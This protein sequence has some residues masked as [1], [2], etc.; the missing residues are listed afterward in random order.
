MFFFKFPVY[1]AGGSKNCTGCFGLRRMGSVSSKSLPPMLCGDKLVWGQVL[2]KACCVLERAISVN[3][4]SISLCSGILREVLTKTHMDFS[5]KSS[6]LQ[7]F[8]PISC[9]AMG[10]FTHTNARSDACEI[11]DQILGQWESWSQLQSEFCIVTMKPICF[12]PSQ[13]QLHFHT[14]Y[15]LLLSKLICKE[16]ASLPPLSKFGIAW[17]NGELYLLEGSLWRCCLM[18][19]NKVKERTC[20]W[21][22]CWI[23]GNKSKT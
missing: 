12:S 6:R 4:K 20:G 9:W 2:S 23:F 1:Q 3:A 18:R 16:I 5:M 7:A 22:S 17:R 21:G 14:W 11:W 13:A 10:A 15:L 19:V 8:S